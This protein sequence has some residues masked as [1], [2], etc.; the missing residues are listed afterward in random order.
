MCEYFGVTEK[1]CVLS[2]SKLCLLQNVRFYIIADD[3]RVAIIRQ[4]NDR[5]RS[6]SIAEICFFMIAC[7]T[8]CHSAETTT[9]LESSIKMVPESMLIEHNAHV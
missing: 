7:T 5:C 4:M 1:V 3:R 8:A 6:L 2:T 9:N